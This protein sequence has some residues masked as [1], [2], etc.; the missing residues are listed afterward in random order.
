MWKNRILV[1]LI[2]MA[3]GTASGYFYL[4]EKI[5][6]G[7]LKIAAGKQQLEDGQKMLAQGKARLANGQGSLSQAKNIYHDVKSV[8]LMGLARYLPVTGTVFSIAHSRIAEGN[9]LVT[10]GQEKINAGEKQLS[11]GKLELSNGEKKLKYANHIRI[12]YAVGAIM[13]T[14]LSILFAYKCKSKPKSRKK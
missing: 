11:E 4:T 1:F 5:T 7:R 2:L 6:S 3:V 12:L 9:Q 14:L 8:P 13:F 10:K